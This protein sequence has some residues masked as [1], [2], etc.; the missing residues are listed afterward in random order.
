MVELSLLMACCC[1]CADHGVV[2]A[3]ERGEIADRRRQMPV[4][5]FS[6]TVVVLLSLL[7]VVLLSL[8]PWLVRSPLA[9]P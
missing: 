6:L 3:A 1:R 4:K 8:S 5:V 2:A 7:V 9:G